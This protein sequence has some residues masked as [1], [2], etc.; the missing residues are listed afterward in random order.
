MAVNDPEPQES[1]RLTKPDP[2]SPEEADARLKKMAADLLR[3]D[4][5]VGQRL[6]AMGRTIREA[7]RRTVAL[8]SDLLNRGRRRADTGGAGQGAGQAGASRNSSNGR[9]P[10]ASAS[11]RNASSAERPGTADSRNSS[12][13]RSASR[14]E[15]RDD[16]LSPLDR[17]SFDQLE[18]LAAYMIDEVM[19]SRTLQK[20]YQ[21]GRLPVLDEVL[22]R[23][24]P[25]NRSEE[26]H[27]SELRAEQASTAARWTRGAVAPATSE[28][29]EDGRVSRLSTVSALT[30]ESEQAQA[31]T[32]GLGR[33]SGESVRPEARLTGPAEHVPTPPDPTQH[34]QERD[35]EQTQGASW[36]LP[37]RPSSSLSD[38]PSWPLPDTPPSQERQRPNAPAFHY[39]QTGLLPSPQ[40]HQV[41]NALTTNDRVGLGGHRA[42]QGSGANTP[43]RPAS[44]VVGAS[45]ASGL[46]H[47]R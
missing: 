43:P 5:P 24:D 9:S 15:D 1:R 29:P 7:W 37:D 27:R 40:S 22:A 32:E 13:Q 19:K 2:G 44:P 17:L 35:Q 31:S 33:T 47:R 4:L 30:S 34:G 36:P 42:S 12:S 23:A 14:G 28:G 26:Q 46:Q 21:D 18:K 10:S 38:S 16:G 20:A 8:L 41:L 45:Q 25:V 11:G 39:P 6:L 3:R